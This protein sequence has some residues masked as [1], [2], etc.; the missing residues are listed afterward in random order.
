MFYQFISSHVTKIRG[1]IFKDWFPY[2]H[3]RS[4]ALRITRDDECGLHGFAMSGERSVLSLLL[5]SPV[6]ER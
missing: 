2:S 3:Q 4:T 1:E 5:H 6:R